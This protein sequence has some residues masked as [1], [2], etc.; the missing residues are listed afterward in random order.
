MDENYRRGAI[1]YVPPAGCFLSIKPIGWVK[2]IRKNLVREWL[3][4]FQ[5]GLRAVVEG[6][7]KEG[8]VV[9]ARIDPP[10]AE[11]PLDVRLKVK[12]AHP[13]QSHPG[14][15]MVSFRFVEPDARLQAYLMTE[16]CRHPVIRPESRKQ[17]PGASAS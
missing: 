11:S 3:D 13:S 1:S 2:L 8:D 7:F 4:V 5:N 16:L 14:C 17:I 9:E 15:S 6:R 10:D 12:H